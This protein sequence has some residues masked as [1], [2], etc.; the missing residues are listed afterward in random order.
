[1]A[2]YLTKKKEL[3]GSSKIKSEL[4]NNLFSMKDWSP[5]RLQRGKMIMSRGTM[6]NH[7]ESF[8]IQ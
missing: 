7:S 3:Y 5:I 6:Q 2:G 4:S 1:M 8:V